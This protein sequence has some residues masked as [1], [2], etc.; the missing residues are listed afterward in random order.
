MLKQEAVKPLR[1]KKEAL[2]TTKLRKKLLNWTKK[3][4]VFEVKQTTK[5]SKYYYSSGSFPKQYDNLRIV[6]KNK[7]WHKH[8]DTSLEGT[9]WD[10]SIYVKTPAY[11]VIFFDKDFY[12]IDI[13][14]IVKERNNGEKFITEERANELCIKKDRV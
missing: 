5:G 6:K 4:S 3:T 10:I 13:D 9:P 7:L 1:G 14:E 8:P 2:L 11:L 12:I